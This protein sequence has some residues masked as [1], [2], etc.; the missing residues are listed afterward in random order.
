MGLTGYIFEY[1]SFLS[2]M[3]TSLILVCIGF[4]LLFT[5]AVLLLRYWVHRRSRHLLPH[6]KVSQKGETIVTVGFFHPYCNAG[7]GGERV[8]WVAIRALQQ[9]YPYVKCVV[10]T[11]DTYTSD[12]NILEKARQRFN[13]VLPKP[14]EFVFLKRRPWVEATKYPI[15]TLLGQSLGSIVLGFE[16]LLSYVP[17]IYV[18]SMGYAFTIPL[19]RYFGGCKV[20][21]YVHY[22]TISTDMLE[23]VSQR[24]ATFN[25]ASFVSQSA[26]FTYI[27]LIYYRLFAALYGLAGKR[28]DFIMVNSTWT[29]G[30]IKSLWQAGDRTVIVYPPC[31]V[32]EFIK[33]SLNRTSENELQ[34]IISIAQFRPEKDHQLQINSFY[35][36]LMK[37]TP[38]ERLRYRLLL[39]GSCRDQN[40]LNRVEQL[41]VLCKELKIKDYVDFKLNVSF[42][43]L[44]DLMAS[45]VIGLHTMRDEHFGIGVVELMAA[46]TV[47][48][49]HNS[50]GP[51][52]DIVTTYN[53]NKT[54]YLAND[55]RSYADAMETIFKLSDEDKLKIRTN[56]R[57][58]VTRFSESEFEHGFLAVID[59]AIKTV[60]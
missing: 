42:Q 39:V 56:A 44:M 40:D 2:Q 33:I 29:F 27:K 20:G 13:I 54:G 53:G 8:L 59:P 38:L 7:G 22:P 34:N 25:N 57:Q 48:L 14:V 4:I 11:G 55:V 36:F 21:C 16:A 26:F 17:D 41:Q 23:R 45:S 18:D 60:S 3:V 19:F 49:A 12:Q 51:M 35:E 58:S 9:R 31:D 50:G 5:I 43:E 24:E 30:H 46:G 1:L 15:F 47:V 52:L 28:S 37:H 32:T 6:L 10:Y